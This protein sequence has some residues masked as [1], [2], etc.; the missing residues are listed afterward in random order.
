MSKHR[1]S[2]K[3]RQVIHVQ[4]AVVVNCAVQLQKMPVKA[5][6]G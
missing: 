6:N 4:L 2:K 1:L 5:N 3:A